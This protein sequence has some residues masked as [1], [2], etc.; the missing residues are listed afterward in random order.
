M[1][2]LHTPTKLR[3]AIPSQ[4]LRSEDAVDAIEEWLKI[5]Q[6]HL[7]EHLLPLQQSHLCCVHTP[8]SLQMPRLCSTAC[9][10][11]CNLHLFLS[12]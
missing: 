10:F 4:V 11:S 6:R 2:D 7:C 9:C 8:T 3:E 5:V 12:V 1:L